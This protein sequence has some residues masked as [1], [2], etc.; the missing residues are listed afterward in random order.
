MSNLAEIERLIGRIALS[1]RAAF[2]LL[3]SATSAK[4]FGVCL[5]VLNNRTDAEEAL[6]DSFIKIWRGADR[7]ASNGLSPMTWLITVARNCAIDR[8]RGRRA[9]GEDLEAADA[10]PDSAP[11][12]EAAAIAGSERRR[13]AA[14]LEELEADRAAAV[15]GAYLSGDTY[16]ELARR[17]GV[18]LNTM[19][20]WL[21]RSL[22]K[23]KDCLS[24]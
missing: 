22:I 9:V 14:C 4:L 16:E 20:T 8:L 6:Q 15:K 18:P 12:P 13:I 24:R 11:S 19:R 23:L 2:D 7:Y 3:Y 17:Y 21:R 1:D 10:V 5:R